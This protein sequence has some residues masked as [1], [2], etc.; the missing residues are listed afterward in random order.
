M[1]QYDIY[2]G[3]AILLTATDQGTADRLVDVLRAEQRA[4]GLFQGDGQ[5]IAAVPVERGQPNRVPD[6]ISGD[7]EGVSLPAID[8]DD[9][10]AFGMADATASDDP[11]EEQL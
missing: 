1:P 9:E 5:R 6:E 7:G 8:E 10:D 4:G 11:H 2:L 3:A